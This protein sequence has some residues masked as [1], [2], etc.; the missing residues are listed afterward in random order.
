MSVWTKPYMPFYIVKRYEYSLAIE[1]INIIYS[2]INPM[3]RGMHW[4]V[5]TIRKNHAS[6]YVIQICLTQKRLWCAIFSRLEA[7]MYLSHGFSSHNLDNCDRKLLTSSCQR[8][9]DQSRDTA[10]SLTLPPQSKTRI[11]N[12][13]ALCNPQEC[14][15]LLLSNTAQAST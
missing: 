2:G 1:M 5:G 7:P 4:R 3:H 12:S 8:V 6:P 13:V 9:V 15:R 11:L 10:D 14:I